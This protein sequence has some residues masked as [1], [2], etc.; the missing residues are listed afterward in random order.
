MHDLRDETA[1]LIHLQTAGA[2]SPHV[3]LICMAAHQ[4]LQNLGPPIAHITVII[5][6]TFI[7]TD[8]NE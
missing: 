1:C 2:C 4:D 8:L 3:G 6:A 5:S 7:F